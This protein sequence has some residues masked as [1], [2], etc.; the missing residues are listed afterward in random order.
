MST[1]MAQ[2]DLKGADAWTV[3]CECASLGDPIMLDDLKAGL[4]I[5]NVVA[6]IYEDRDNATLDRPAFKGFSKFIDENHWRYHACKKVTYGSFYGMQSQKMMEGILKDS[7][8]K[9]GVPVYV[10]PKICDEIQ[11]VAVFTR[12]P[13][14][15]LRFKYY[16]KMLL[17][18]GRLVTETGHVR[19][20]QGRK[21]DWKGGVRVVNADTH[22]EALA[23]E[24]QLMT[25]YVNNLAIRN[26]WYDEENYKEDG[27]LRVRPLLTVHD[28]GIYA[29]DEEDKEFAKV[30]LRQWYTNEITIAGIKVTIPFSGTIGTDWSMKESEPI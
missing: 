21:A 2:C 7:Y 30:K 11:Q 4:K 14:I 20:F 9:G 12:Y 24:P 17:N 22:R 28:S 18:E 26:C 6:L 29:L 27:S 16:E 8:G 13:G 5:H 23:T 19:T 1:L 25:T 15:K 3:A 10:A